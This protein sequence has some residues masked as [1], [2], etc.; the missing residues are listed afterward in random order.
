MDHNCLWDHPQKP[1]QC[2]QSQCRVSRHLEVYT[3]YLRRVLL[4]YL[5]YALTKPIDAD[6]ITSNWLDNQIKK[7]N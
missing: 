1:S 4:S 5:S 7:E 6:Y 2:K 3:Q